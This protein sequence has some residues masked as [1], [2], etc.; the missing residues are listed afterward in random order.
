MGG[1]VAGSVARFIREI[2]LSGRREGEIAGLVILILGVLVYIIHGGFPSC[3][4]AFLILSVLTAILGWTIGWSPKGKTDSGNPFVLFL[5][6]M[7]LAETLLFLF[8]AIGGADLSRI[9]RKVEFAFS[10]PRMVVADS[11][12][13]VYVLSDTTCRVQ[14]YDRDGRFEVGW[15]SAHQSKNPGL[16][17][18]AADNIY[19]LT[20]A[21]DIYTASGALVKTLTGMG[22]RPYG[23]GVWLLDDSGEVTSDQEAPVPEP[24]AY[25][26][27]L[28]PGDTFPDAVG[29]GSYRV[30]FEAPDGTRYTIRYILGI[31]PAVEVTRGSE[32]VRWICPNVFSLPFGLPFP[33][34]LFYFLLLGVWRKGARRRNVVP[35]SVR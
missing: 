5:L 13:A 1:K 7:A 28:L 9:L 2:P 34:L 17:I 19:L 14:K 6:A 8:V 24:P 3:F 4:L 15:G 32:H 26:H 11:E 30:G 23:Y 21:C 35:N 27:P 25:A 12:G 29:R 31:F 10:S 16:A 18:D 22:P 20:T 33:G